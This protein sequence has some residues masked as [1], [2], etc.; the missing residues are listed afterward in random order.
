M[1]RPQQRVG[2]DVYLF[3]L[4]TYITVT[5][6]YRMCFGVDARGAMKVPLRARGGDGGR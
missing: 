1:I 6:P 4:L 5:I 3:F 2:W